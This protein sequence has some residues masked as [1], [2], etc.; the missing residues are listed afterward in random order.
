M[1]VP[2]AREDLQPNPRCEETKSVE[3][4][5]RSMV[6]CIKWRWIRSSARLTVQLRARAVF[7]LYGDIHIHGCMLPPRTVRSGC[8]LWI[9]ALIAMFLL[10]HQC[11]LLV[12]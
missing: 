6:V 7:L 4:V 8:A 3:R 2:L 11:C 9:I 12:V 1:E 10:E 5:A